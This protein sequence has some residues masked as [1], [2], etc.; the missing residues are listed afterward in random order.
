MGYI[1]KKITFPIL[2]SKLQE[3]VNEV[4]Y[5]FPLINIKIRMFLINYR[6]KVYVH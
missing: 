5:R 4:I 3:N 2:T 6:S 1:L